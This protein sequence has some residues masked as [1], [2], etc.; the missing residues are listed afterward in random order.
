MNIYEAGL[1]A[2]III[3]LIHYGAQILSSNDMMF[4]KAAR[5]DLNLNISKTV[6]DVTA[7]TIETIYADKEKAFNDVLSEQLNNK[8][9]A[10]GESIDNHMQEWQKNIIAQ[11]N[12]SFDEANKKYQKQLAEIRMTYDKEF[13]ALYNGLF[14]D[15]CV[16]AR[17]SPTN[18]TAQAMFTTIF[19]T[20]KGRFSTETSQQDDKQT[21]TA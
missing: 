14:N 9:K 5:E 18:P 11:V 17:T 1:S 20:L 4:I 2:I 3:A 12:D 13:T 10:I 19:P 15:F 21:A 8:E 16:R 7:K 6:T